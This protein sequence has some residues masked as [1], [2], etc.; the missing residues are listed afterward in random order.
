[1]SVD[2]PALTRRQAL[3]AG[4]TGALALAL[5]ACGATRAPAPTGSTLAGTW[6]DPSGAGELR[7]G[8]GAPFIERTE[9][10]PRA[11]LGGVLATLAHV[12]DAHVLD[13]QSPARVP[14]LARLGPP[15][16]STFRPQEAL[17]AQVLDGALRA[18]DALAPDAVVQGGDVIDNA[19]AN[20]LTRALAT[21]HGGAVDPNSGAPGYFGV[22]WAGDP[23][24]FYYRPDVDAPRHP[25]ML[26]AATAAFRARGLRA[27]CYPVLGDHDLLVQG[28]VAPSA[29]TDAIARGA[30]AVWELPEG[31]R[32]PAAIAARVSAS[33]PDGLPTATL[34]N[35]LIERL[36]SAPSVSV[37]P[38]PR[39]H[40]LP[41]AAVLGALRRAADLADDGPLLDYA[42]ALGA[43]VYAI[44]LD[45]VRREGGSGGLVHPGQLRWLKAQ[46]AAAGERWVLVFSHQPLASTAGGAGVLALL[47]RHPRVLAAISGH[48]HRN[49]IT[50]RPGPAGGYWLISTAS[51]IDYPQQ[52]RALRVRSTPTGA[53]LQTWMLDHVPGG[54][55][56]LGEISRELAYLDAQGGRPQGF[57][58]TPL[59]RNV[60]L[61]RASA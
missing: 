48:T 50:P 12:T 45:L 16:T 37:P 22:Q 35:G 11:R 55:A 42:F 26:A 43:H 61:Y 31:L 57:A 52:A 23:D 33:A 38:D 30:R 18:I 58:G 47:D 3:A 21:L 34:L 17:S 36:Q 56:G 49:T 41:A 39:R 51:L 14:F 1:V 6:T 8:A 9:L 19:Q 13:S 2:G 4:A 53:A 25:G 54:V 59:D 60:T 28:V 40:E 44:V 10:A 29:L 32:V 5:G 15:F 7:P 24:P 46:L 20:E 27:R